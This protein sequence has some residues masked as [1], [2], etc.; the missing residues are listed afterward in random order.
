[1]ANRMMLAIGLLRIAALML[2][3]VIVYRLLTVMLTTAY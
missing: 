3:S 2:A 1:M